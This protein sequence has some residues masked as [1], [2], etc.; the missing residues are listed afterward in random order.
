MDMTHGYI[1]GKIP[2]LSQQEMRV[3]YITTRRAMYNQAL[4]DIIEDPGIPSAAARLAGEFYM[5]PQGEAA[6]IL[7][8]LQ[9]MSRD[10]TL[11]GQARRRATG[12]Q[13]AIGGRAMGLLDFLE[14][15]GKD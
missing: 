9:T 13:A 8:N 5:A 10:A 3:G 7:G 1:S 11:L 14:D 6:G 15:R 2:I 4:S 12:G